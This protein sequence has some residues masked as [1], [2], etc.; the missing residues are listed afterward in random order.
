MMIRNHI[1]RSELRIPMAALNEPQ[2]QSG[3]GDHR[4]FGSR[5]DSNLLSDDQLRMINF[6]WSTADNQTGFWRAERNFCSTAAAKIS[7]RPAAFKY[8][9]LNLHIPN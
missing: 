6:G 3:S 9:L 2:S 5:V 4:D 7:D 8:W 1:K